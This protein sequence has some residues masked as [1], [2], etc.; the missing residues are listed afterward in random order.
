MAR[1]WIAISVMTATALVTAFGITMAVSYQLHE[2]CTDQMAQRG[3][4]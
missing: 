2:R 1:K 3:D 4:C